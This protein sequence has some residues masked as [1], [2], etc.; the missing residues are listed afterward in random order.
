MAAARPSQIWLVTA[1]VMALGLGLADPSEI[2][3]PPPSVG[4]AYGEPVLAVLALD[5]FWPM[6]EW[7]T[8]WLQESYARAPALVLGLALLVVAPLVALLG[9]AS[10]SVSAAARDGERTVLVRRRPAPLERGDALPGA[11][12]EAAWSAQAWV[13]I[14]GRPE[15]RWKVGYGL[16]RV[17]REEDNEIRFASRTV[18]RYHAVIH[19][20]ADQD[21]VVTDL[22]GGGNGVLVNGHRIVEAR[23]GDGDRIGIGGETLKF[24]IA[25]V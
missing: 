1:P 15:R 5:A 10:R 20:T 8:S 25:R 7:L 11:V 3:F 4:L 23:L 22:S 13:E 24:R 9:F 21:F 16:V 19:R 6:L 2:V 12:P 17:G 14:D 18:H